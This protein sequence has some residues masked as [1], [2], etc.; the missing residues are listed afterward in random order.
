MTN[1]EIGLRYPR[2]IQALMWVACLSHGE[3][4]ACIRDHRQNFAYSSEAVNHFGG[5][6]RCLMAAA[7]QRVRHLML[8]RRIGVS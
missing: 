6:K 2:L 4:V 7:R 1:A 3:A 8:D 5:T